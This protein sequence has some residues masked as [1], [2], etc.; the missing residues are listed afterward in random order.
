MSFVQT[1]LIS[2]AWRA[3]AISERVRLWLRV[4]KLYLLKFR[5]MLIGGKLSGHKPKWWID[6][7][8][9]P[10]NR[11]SCGSP[12]RDLT[13]SDADAHGSNHACWSLG[14]RVDSSVRCVMSPLHRAS[15][16]WMDRVDIDSDDALVNLAYS[17]GILFQKEGN[18]H[19][20]VLPLNKSQWGTQRAYIWTEGVRSVAVVVIDDKDEWFLLSDLDAAWAAG[21]ILEFQPKFQE[22]R[23]PM[24]QIVWVAKEWRRHGIGKTL[25]KKTLAA[26]SVQVH[27]VIWSLPMTPSGLEL[28]KSMAGGKPIRLHKGD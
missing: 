16:H 13:F 21:N 25:I 6:E 8:V 20:P 11:C 5:A 22:Q 23:L 19:K 3:L 9:T 26:E 12:L 27:E 18:Q 10:N 17:L 4:S 28:A 24:I 7:W 14:L 1:V 15:S 2:T